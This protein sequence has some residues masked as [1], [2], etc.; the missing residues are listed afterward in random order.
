[1]YMNNM[2]K[3]SDFIDYLWSEM[4]ITVVVLLICVIF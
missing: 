4:G 2:L 1:M 3:S